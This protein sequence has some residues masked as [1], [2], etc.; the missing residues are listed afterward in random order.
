MSIKPLPTLRATTM[1]FPFTPGQQ[2]SRSD[3]NE[4]LEGQS[5]R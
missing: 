3:R 4:E 1:C 2:L 5:E